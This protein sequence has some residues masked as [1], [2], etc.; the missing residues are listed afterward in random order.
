MKR[1]MICLL[2]FAACNSA[3]DKNNL[4]SDTVSMQVPQQQVMTDTVKTTLE[5]SWQLQP[6][7]ASD[8]AAGKIPMLVFDLKS[9]K[10]QGN[11][12]CNNM[13]GSFITSGDSLSFNEQILMTKMA[14]AGYNEAGFIQSLTKVNH[15]KIEQGVLQLLQDQTILSKWIRKDATV[16]KKI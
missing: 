5:G 1:Y 6:V 3:T 13:S 8:T 10:F 14:C 12:G 4:S 15:F 7:L 11:T 9:K 16:Q 2:F